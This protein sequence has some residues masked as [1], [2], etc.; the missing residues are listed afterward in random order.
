[1]NKLLED[2]R[3]ELI[4]NS[5]HADNYA[6]ENQFRGKNR[7]ERRLHSRVANSVREM[8]SIDMNKFFQNNILDVDVKVRGETN[9]YIVRISFGE[10]LDQIHKQ[11]AANN[12]VLNLRCVIRALVSSF[13]GENVYVRCSCPDFCLVGDT[14]IKLL[15]G[16]I[17]P[18]KDIFNKFEN[19]EELWVY[20]SDEKGDFKPGKVSNVWISGYANDFIKVTLDNDRE[21]ITT[22]N[23]RYM[24]RNGDYC[25][26]QNLQVGTSLMPMYF[27]YQNGYE[28]YKKN[29]DVG[30]TRFFS[31]YKE[32]ANECLKDEIEV[33]K[34]RSGED[35]VA[36]HHVDFNKLNNYPSN[37]SPMGK[38]EHWN[39]HAVHN[40][41]SGN[42]DRWR[43]AGKTY[44]SKQESKDT[45]AEVMR[46]VIHEWWQNMSP[47]EYEY[48]CR[49]ISEQ[50]N[51]AE[52][53]KKRSDSLK[54]VW[55]NYTE[56]EYNKRCK[57]N[58]ESNRKAK[59]KISCKVKKYWENLSE[60]EYNS[61]CENNR[62]SSKTGWENHK[63]EIIK[64]RFLK[65]FQRIID[66]GEEIT[67][68]NYQKYKYTPSP[69]WSNYF[70]SFEECKAFFG[71][72]HSVKSIET[73]HSDVAV[74]VY[75]MQVDKYENFLVGAGVL[76]HNCYRQAYYLSVHDIIVGDKETRPSNITNPNDTKG[77]G[78]KHILL[79][80]SNNSWLTKVASVIFN[81]IRYMEQHYPN[82]YADVIYPAIYQ[83]EYTGDVQLQLQPPEQKPEE[84]Q[85]DISVSA[86]KDLLNVAN[87][88]ARTKTQFQKGNEYRFQKQNRPMKR[89]I[90]FDNLISD[91]EN[92]G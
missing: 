42:F 44:W 33:A 91:S 35:N 71:L 36:I 63:E 73:I 56:D 15:N 59:E 19:N 31:V 87:K 46:H 47:E 70:K 13:N 21:I 22:P 77:R 82:M 30:V 66:S 48:N 16:Q 89:Q 51:R 39:Y 88:W 74:P 67:E 80:L 7:Y 45:Q 76:L 58:K 50:N 40:V 3:Q 90:D 14:E 17:L 28:N 32:V 61:R 78:C 79:V 25:E 41:E 34:K 68:E 62:H 9:D 81:Y 27:S 12:D 5:K 11:L 84:G 69:V 10:V 55:E 86:D 85:P 83:R 60:E 26:A 75:D 6:P 64:G 43:E 24:L 54:S 92:A 8:N 18:I 57:I 23:H 2:K 29:S 52:V 72:N 38:L 20:S 65:V 53:R 49:R 37:L 4:S 1:M